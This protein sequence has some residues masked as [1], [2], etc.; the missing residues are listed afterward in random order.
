MPV[1]TSACRHCGANVDDD[2]T[3]CC[4]GCEAAARLI[5]ADGLERYRALA[6]GPLPPGRVPSPRAWLDRDAV[7]AI[8][9]V[10]GITCGACVWVIEKV[11]QK[12]DV[13]CMVNPGIGRLSVRAASHDALT[14]FLDDVE[15]L[16]YR[17]GPPR[18]GGDGA[19]DALV[20]RAGICGALAMAAMSFA[21]ARYF[22]LDAASDGDHGDV[23][24]AFLLGEVASAT[25]AVVVGG[26]YFEANTVR[27]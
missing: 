7:D 26:S 15:T 8:V 4:I 23:A 18:K 13:G 2:D 6:D 5:A 17:L 3:Y 27:A 1:A 10:Q 9:D 25:L 11:A 16:G 19:I 22:G 14:G 21:F 24:A 20:L 12:R